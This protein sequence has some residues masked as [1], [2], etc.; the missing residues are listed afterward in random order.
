[1]SSPTISTKADARAS[2]EKTATRSEDD[3]EDEFEQL[4]NFGASSENPN[5][6]SE[7]KMENSVNDDDD[8][9][10]EVG[11]PTKNKSSLDDDDDDLFDIGTPKDESTPIERPKE[12]YVNTVNTPAEEKTLDDDLFFPVT[13]APPTENNDDDDDAFYRHDEGTRD[14]LEWLDKDKK[15]EASTE[16]TKKNTVDLEKDILATTPEKKEPLSSEELIQKDKEEAEDDDDDEFEKV[17]A[18]VEVLDDDEEIE[19]E[20]G[21]AIEDTNSEDEEMEFETLSQ[22][23]QSTDGTMEQIRKQFVVDKVI[24]DEDRKYLWCKAM[25]SGKTYFDI[26]D[27]SCADSYLNWTQE[28]KTEEDQ[29]HDDDIDKLTAKIANI[30]DSS[31]SQEATF[32]KDDLKKLLMYRRRAQQPKSSPK[33]EETTTQDANYESIESLAPVAALLLHVGIESQVASVIL[34]SIQTTLP[35]SSLPSMEEQAQACEPL[36]TQLYLLLCY[37]NPT[38]VIHLDRHISGWQHSLIPQTFFV[39]N[40]VFATTSTDLASSKKIIQKLVHLWDTFFLNGDAND[41]KFFLACSLFHD[42]SDTLLMLRGEDLSK[43]LN[44]IMTFMEVSD[45]SKNMTDATFVEHN[46]N[47]SQDNSLESTQHTESDDNEDAASFIHKWRQRALSLKDLTPV[48]VVSNLCSAED[49]AINHSLIIRNKRAEE[50]LKQKLEEEAQNHRLA[51]EKKRT[52]NMHKERLRNFY[53]KN[54]P[55]KTDDEIEHIW[56]VYQDRLELLDSRLREKYNNQGFMPTNSVLNSTFSA[57]TNKLLHTMGHGIQIRRKEIMAYRAD[58]RAKKLEEGLLSSSHTTAYGLVS[59]KVNS[60]E[61]LPVSCGVQTSTSHPNNLKYFLVD[62][63]PDDTADEQGRFP[64]AMRLSPEALMDPDLYHQQI[65]K[66]ESLRGAVHVCIIVSLMIF[67]FPIFI[68]PLKINHHITFDTYQQGVGFSAFQKLYN[69]QLS[70]EE[71]KLLEDDESRANMCALFFIKKGFPF[72][73]I[74]DG[75]FA[76]E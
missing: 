65:D 53:K 73:S 69:H 71:E 3:E 20:D 63:R 72:V 43:E 16:S 27:G 7:K 12:D 1:M 76:G 75:G 25:T 58:R 60:D 11:S 37:H 10:F 67:K 33:K 46:N 28:L 39:T 19:D 56:D 35:L 64:T 36:E 9:I 54:N 40:Y 5:D 17:M 61:V 70:K 38:L 23:I 18:V 42:N 34:S 13:V 52:Q 8:D 57:Q 15:P 21:V 47:D 68:S 31:F 30:Y 48:S 6:E 22:A 74:L 41:M 62:S 24:S 66:F 4:F 51:M 29:L 55:E 59:L 45:E 44:H 50:K 2:T 32:P 14:F 26:K 49:E